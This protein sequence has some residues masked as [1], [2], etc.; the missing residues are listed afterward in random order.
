MAPRSRRTPASLPCRVEWHGGFRLDLATVRAH[1]DYRGAHVV[2][3][4][5]EIAEDD[6]LDPVVI[7]AAVAAGRHD[8]QDLKQVWHHLAR[9][10]RPT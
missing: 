7:G 3:V 1:P 5:V 8:P 10:G 9:F 2:D 4:A 6:H